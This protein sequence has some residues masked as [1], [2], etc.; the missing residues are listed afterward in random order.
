MLQAKARSLK[1]LK[2]VL[3][4]GGY[5]GQP[6]AGF[7]REHTGAS[8]QVAKRSKLHTF[9]VIPKRWVVEQPIS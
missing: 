6:F 8:V 7:V 4:D 5:D 3:V 9:A 1:K 2:S